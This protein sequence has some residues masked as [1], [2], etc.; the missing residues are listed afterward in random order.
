M[1]IKEKLIDFYD[2]FLWKLNHWKISIKYF[3]EGIKRWFSYFKTVVFTYDFSY[4]S[5][6]SV[7]KLQLI[8]L[9]NTLIKCQGHKNWKE[10]V[11]RITLALRLLDI[12]EENGC[13]K[14]VGISVYVNIQNCK[15]FLSVFDKKHYNNPYH[16]NIYKDRLRIEKAW[17]LYHKLKAQYMRNWWD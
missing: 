4:D 9:R 7:E 5:V 17:N 8:R 3:I 13:S 16:G 14:K 15:R 1:K 11:N 12:I 6:L 10:D 2:D